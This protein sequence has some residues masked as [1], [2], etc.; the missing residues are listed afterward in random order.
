MPRLVWT[1]EQEEIM[2]HGMMRHRSNAWL[3]EKTGK[4]VDEVR[5][6]KRHMRNAD[7][8]EEIPRSALIEMNR[9]AVAA[10]LAAHPER[11]CRYQ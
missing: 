3:S 10:L 9:A 1:E 7:D 11:E 8:Y 2:R 5:S 4:T 6:K